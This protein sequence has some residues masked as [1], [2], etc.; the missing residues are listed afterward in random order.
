MKTFDWETILPM[1][2]APSVIDEQWNPWISANLFP[3]QHY[4]TQDGPFFVFY[5]S[6]Q[7]SCIPTTSS[8]LSYK[9]PSFCLSSHL[10]LLF[11]NKRVS[12]GAL[13]TPCGQLWFI[14]VRWDVRSSRRVGVLLGGVSPLLPRISLRLS[15]NH[16]LWF[17]WIP[18]GGCYV[19]TQL[20]KIFLH[21]NNAAYW[22]IYI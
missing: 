2:S 4:Y 10:D 9:Y 7:G 16:Q 21:G 20:Q 3:I 11:I 6:F 17:V 14:P 18:F 1:S 19:Q 12:F 5:D 22:H 8:D 15:P 13:R